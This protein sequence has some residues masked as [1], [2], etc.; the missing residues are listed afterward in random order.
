[1]GGPLLI[2]AVTAGAVSS[3][4]DQVLL[5]AGI[6]SISLGMLNLIMPFPPF[7]GGQM[8]IAFVEM[9]RKGRRLSYK[10]QELLFGTGT[11]AAICLFIAVMWAD[12]R[13]FTMPA[14]NSAKPKVE[15]KQSPA[16]QPSKN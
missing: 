1:M 2:A 10:A 14:P 16:P 15:Q 12:I 7:D 8:V 3:G 13:R 5:L 6:L 11:V 4:L 9:F